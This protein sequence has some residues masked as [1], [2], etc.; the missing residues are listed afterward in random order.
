MKKQYKTPEIETLNVNVENL[1]GAASDG[2]GT[3]VTI[4]DTNAQYDAE[5]RESDWDE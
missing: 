1:L 5:S 3:S 2:N 4:N